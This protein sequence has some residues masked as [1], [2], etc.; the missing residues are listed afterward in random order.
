[1]L[2]L[3]VLAIAGILAAGAAFAQPARG[4]AEICLD[5]Q[6]AEDA[7]IIAVCTRLIDAGVGTP[8]E[9]AQYLVERGWAF[10]A[11]RRA[12]AIADYTAA[13]A[14][15]ATNAEAFSARGYHLFLDADYDGAATDYAAAATLQ[16]Y[17]F[18]YY[19]LATAWYRLDRTDEAL[20]AL[21]TAIGIDPDYTS[22]YYL[23]GFIRWAGDEDAAALADFT[24]LTELSPLTARY[25]EALG[26]VHY[27]MGNTAEAIRALSSAIL[28][29]PNLGDARFML[30]ELTPGQP[31]DTTAPLAYV[32]PPEGLRITFVEVIGETLPVLDPMEAAIRALVGFF[33]AETD[34]PEPTVRRMAD[35]VFGPTTA[36]STEV[37]ATLLRGGTEPPVTL[38]HLYGLWQTAFPPGGPALTIAYDGGLAAFWKLA[39]GGSVD[40]AGDVLF[41]CP[42]Q[43]NPLGIL[44]GCTPGVTEAR[45]GGTRIT[46]TFEGWEY[47][48]VPAGQRLAARVSFSETRSLTLAGQTMENSVTGVWWLDP[49]IGFW[50]R[51]EQNQDGLTQTI[52]AYTIEPPE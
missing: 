28:L 36:Q 47:V 5:P 19:D 9:Q 44:L 39:P 4:D 29:D 2:R 23:R 43:V 21:D 52:A 48:V 26:T 25:Q 51:R 8:A 30:E 12:D 13:I 20:R 38:P 35:R 17:A 6:G 50:I 34:Y 32:P 49:T 16:P 37:T 40:V 11:D 14:L 3:A 27:R 46:A 15:D 42:P 33:A 22:A 31:A 1:M 18:R 45:V 10:G 24:R 7:E 41:P